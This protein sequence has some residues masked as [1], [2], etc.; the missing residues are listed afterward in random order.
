MRDK[1]EKLILQ[2]EEKEA[3]DL[4]RQAQDISGSKSSALFK[5]F[6]EI[7]YGDTPLTELKEKGPQT[8][9]A[10]GH[11]LWKDFE[12]YER[13]SPK[14]HAE[15]PSTITFSK[16]PQR[17]IIA[18]IAKDSSFLIDSLIS[19]ITQSGY[20][21]H[22]IIHPKI[23]VSRNTNHQVGG[24][25][26]GDVSS[27]DQMYEAVIYIELNDLLDKDEILGL[28]KQAGIILQDVYKTVTDWPSMR[29]K[30]N[31]AV[32]DIDH[33]KSYF[34]HEEKLEIQA[35]LQWLDRGYFTFLGYREYTYEPS[36]RLVESLGILK[37]FRGCLFTDN[38][39]I[40]DSLFDPSL[41]QSKNFCI[42]KTRAISTVH[43]LVPMDVVR[44][45]KFDPNG[46]ICGERQF[47][48]LFTSSVYNRS[49][50]DIPLLRKQSYALLERCGFSPEWHNGKSLMHILE[51]FPRDELFQAT[52]DFLYETI[53]AIIHL[54]ERQKLA[55]FVRKDS[56]GHMVSCLIYVPRDRFSS[57]LR[58]KFSS[59]LSKE[60][61]GSILSFKTEM[62]GDLAFARVH[63]LIATNPLEKPTKNLEHVEDLLQK[64]SMTWEDLLK[65][66]FMQVHGI[67]ARK[68]FKPFS[69]AFS[70]A[71]QEAFSVQDALADI[72]TI[73]QKLEEVPLAI[74]LYQEEL[75]DSVSTYLK[76]YQKNEPLIISDILPILENM[77][78]KVITETPYQITLQEPTRT[79]WLHH[80]KLSFS[81]TTD[82]VPLTNIREN[83]HE[84]L[85]LVWAGRVEN[86]NFNALIVNAQL[87][88]RD[89]VLL[90]VYFKYLKQI[91]FPFDQSFVQ[92]TLSI[93]SDITRELILLFHM[94][95]DP[96]QPEVKDLA[97]KAHVKK[98]EGNFKAVLNA[99]DDRILRSF[100]NLILSTLRT[101]YFVVD[102]QTHQLK[103]YI[104]IKFN[105]S[106]VMG[107]PLP[108][109]AFEIFV[110]AP[111]VEAIHLRGGK[112]ARGGLR[113]STRLDFRKEILDLMKAQMVKNTVII[114]VGAKGGFVIKTPTKHLSYEDLQKQ[115]IFCY[116]TMI[117]GLLDITDNL[118]NGKPVRPFM[119]RCQDEVDPYLVVA[120]DKGTATFSDIA[121]AISNDY[122]FWMSDAFASGGSVGYDHKKMGI[123]AKGA[124]ISVA[125]HFRE[126]DIHVQKDPITVVGV[127]D[128][129]GDVFGNGLLLSDTL[130]LIGAFNHIHI[131]LDP[132]P[133][134]KK[135]FQER[136]RLF[137]LSRS[138]WKDY[139]PEVLSKGGMIIDRSEKTIELTPEIKKYFNIQQSTLT[140]NVIIQTLLKFNADLLWFGGIGTFVKAATESHEQAGD[141][142]NDDIRI[143]GADL[144]CKV[145]GEGANL[146]MTQKGRIEY[147]RLGGRLNTDAIDNS[148]GVDC[149]D[150][151]VNIKI[152]LQ[153]PDL[154]KT[155]SFK[156]RNVLLEQMTEEVA[157]LVLKNN[158]HQTQAISIIHLCGSKVIGRQTRLMHA[159]EKSGRL[160]REIEYL[161]DDK[162]LN[163]RIVE[164]IGLTRPEISV[165]L[166]YGKI[167]SFNKIIESSLPDSPLLF[168]NLLSYF[169]SILQ[170]NFKD[171]I[172]KH[173]LRREIIS[174]L[175]ANSMV[176]CMG[177]TFLNE[178]IEL[179]NATTEEVTLAY[180]LVRESFSLTKLWEEVESLDHAIAAN[181]QYRMFLEIVDLI[182]RNTLWLLRH[183]QR[184]LSM[185]KDIQCFSISAQEF[186]TCIEPCLSGIS[187]SQ[188]EQKISDF[189]KNEVPSKLAK[190]FG[191]L[192]FINFAYTII[193]SAQ[194][195]RTP[196]SSTA[197]LF[198]KLHERFAIDWL[199]EKMKD[200][201]NDS[202]SKRA[203][204]SMR[205]QCL[206]MNAALVESVVREFPLN[207]GL[208]ESLDQWYESRLKR[209]EKIDHLLREIK[210]YEKIDLNMIFVAVQHLEEII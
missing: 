194:K 95:F 202:W 28:K 200:L 44:V 52:D 61:K 50:Q 135:S 29:S 78:L 32:F 24:L 87:G 163:D 68:A 56:L 43:R 180:L 126:L 77:G 190:T 165:L 107:L 131:F 133:D 122:Q 167:F 115:G 201:G 192:P 164:G 60:F 207:K 76:L 10:I 49:I 170:S 16:S 59:I 100:L 89:I 181:I 148:A 92:K 144:R 147:A 128:M 109:P 63:F 91:N 4:I 198:F 193:H 1:V 98:I 159:M 124:W 206:D 166:A 73:Q 178:M 208:I 177:P 199:L 94:L 136:Q 187:S 123:T 18:I 101:N 71:Y 15:C 105:S 102:P 143:N 104:S 204:Y 21:I 114:P 79:V 51:S 108:R 93:Y 65:E 205:D 96:N 48:G 140:P 12:T 53:R 103:D 186:M 69:K 145:I 195:M 111:W 182:E 156:E 80:F 197:L 86:D 57:S 58:E 174:N 191:T 125:R 19:F 127:G 22:S 3:L 36:L 189:T 30:I 168:K 185:A 113:W 74:H 110:Y 55:L 7:L 90:R 138:T 66:R 139:D 120:A 160:N 141:R 152:L 42:T 17:T 119:V 88:W 8:L 149:S 64:A 45:K 155:M 173:P 11:F 161:P 31:D 171:S 179:S 14:I 121:N 27:K 34:S 130:K 23:L 2:K 162:T 117:R 35:F 154:K 38:Q 188:R 129:S 46:K 210:T 25:E 137:K 70:A 176:N 67:N 37:N 13:T 85:A 6:L 54:K 134:P 5:K 75:T 82:P 20:S 97:I 203:L 99:N 26:S 62:G 158:Y 169:P 142:I 153:D 106:A 183:Q 47:F 118:V 40:E 83:F 33:G 72:S 184:T 41:H 151:E 209:I 150:H 84:S 196:I 175:I 172:E 116:Q 81:H 132:T 39:S 9:H 157:G 146:G 112:V